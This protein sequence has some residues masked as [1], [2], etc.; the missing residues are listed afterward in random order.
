M[1]YT[2]PKPRTLEY[3]GRGDWLQGRGVEST[4]IV[5]NFVRIQGGT[6][7]RA[8]I[9]PSPKLSREIPRRSKSP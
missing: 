4:G 5:G 8:Y 9:G 6:V 2:V 1:T 7:P 3:E